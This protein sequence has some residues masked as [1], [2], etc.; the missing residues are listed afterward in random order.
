MAVP[1]CNS[2]ELKYSCDD[3]LRINSFCNDPRRTHNFCDE[4]RQV[5]IVCNDHSWINTICNARRRNS[6]EA[7]RELLLNQQVTGSR[8]LCDE[9]QPPPL[10]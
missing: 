2:D 4:P 8:L 5:G 9:Q 3:H 7:D 1:M 10:W 6:L